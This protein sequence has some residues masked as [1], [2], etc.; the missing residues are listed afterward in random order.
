MTPIGLT[1]KRS[2]N[3]YGSGLGELMI[4]HRCEGCHQFSINRIAAD[5]CSDSIQQL[6]H[7]TINLPQADRCELIHSDI[8]LV[9]PDHKPEILACLYGNLIY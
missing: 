1:W 2:K 3:K 8:E 9:K 6:F 5:D 4:V 7:R